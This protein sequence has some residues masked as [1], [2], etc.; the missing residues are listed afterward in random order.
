[1]KVEIISTVNEFYNKQCNLNAGI[2]VVKTPYGN[3][4]VTRNN[5]ELKAITFSISG[6]TLDSTTQSFK[7][8]FFEALGE[9]K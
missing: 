1:M 6:T 7:N 9:I 8:A 4:T 5:E 2:Y 3:Y